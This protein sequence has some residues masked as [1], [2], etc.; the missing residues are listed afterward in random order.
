MPFL[1]DTVVP[2][3]VTLALWSRIAGVSVVKVIVEAVAFTSEG[4]LMLIQPP[5]GIG[6]PTFK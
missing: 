5:T 2:E 4:N 3:S 1:I 6:F